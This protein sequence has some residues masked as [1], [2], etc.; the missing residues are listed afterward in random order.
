MSKDGFPALKPARPRRPRN[1]EVSRN[2]AMVL[3]LVRRNGEVSRADLTEHTELSKQ[4]VGRI[5]DALMAREF[6]QPGGRVVSGPG[7]PSTM[8]R[9]VPDSAYALG[10]SMTSDSIS[11]VLMKFDGTPIEQLRAPVGG[12]DAGAL[13]DAIEQVCLDL[14]R[15]H[16][17]P[18]WKV[19]GLGLAIPGYFTGQGHHMNPP[20]PLTELAALEID[21]E[22]AERLQMPVWIENDANA[23][24]IGE[25]MNGVG[26]RVRD[27]AYI[28]HTYGLGGAIIINNQLVR[29]FHGNAG[30][31]SGILAPD[32]L[33][34]R[35]TMELL[36]QYVCEGGVP[37]AD[38]SALVTDFHLDWPG[39]ERW[40]DTV[41]AP[42][43]KIITSIASVLDPQAIVLGG[44]IP[45]PLAARLKQRITFYE[46]KKR[47]GQHQ[48][49][50]E[51][52]VSE[53]EGDPT[54]LGAA[55]IP[56]KASFYV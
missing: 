8:I 48:P 53:V 33:E 24:A 19:C 22:M 16:S 15:A 49:R 30:E 38:I 44:Q 47:R 52:L 5:V 18:Q 4:S 12:R 41:C 28:H 34:I 25:H 14:I 3:D 10:V 23:S 39:V 2:E 26:R 6:L 51:I 9:L 32:L 54:A 37:L 29:G 20:D 42:L 35:P 40:I 7:K 56:L 21:R 50:P 45:K 13:L 43:S 11:G 17:L 46:G 36:R 27:F 31:Y 1:F 55:A